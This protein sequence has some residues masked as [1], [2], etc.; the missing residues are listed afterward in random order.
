VD[1]RDRTALTDVYCLNP[2]TN[3]L[4]D[5]LCRERAVNKH[6]DNMLSDNMLFY[7]IRLFD[8]IFAGYILLDG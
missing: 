8:N 4:E 5:P 7:N 2:G 1:V 3:T 6:P